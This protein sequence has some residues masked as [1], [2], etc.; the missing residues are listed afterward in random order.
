M[1][2]NAGN[3]FKFVVNVVFRVVHNVSTTNKLC[4]EMW[5]KI[6]ETD[7]KV[8]LNPPPF[9]NCILDIAI[10]SAFPQINKK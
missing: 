5:S 9:W 4:G 10:K 8:S 7:G 6:Y 1:T 3:K 2:L